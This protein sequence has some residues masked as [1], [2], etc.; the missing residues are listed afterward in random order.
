MLHTGRADASAGRACVHARFRSGAFGI[1]ECTGRCMQALSVQI[2]PLSTARLALPAWPI[3][4]I[5]AWSDRLQPSRKLGL[6][7]LEQEIRL[8]RLL[9]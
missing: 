7:G 2:V 8:S 5:V 3:V 6:V 9:R 4:G 1:A